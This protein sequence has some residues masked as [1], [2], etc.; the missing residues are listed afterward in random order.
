[1]AFGLV[2]YL[3]RAADSPKIESVRNAGLLF[4][5]NQAGVTGVDAGYSIPIGSQTLWMFGDVFLEDPLAPSKQVVGALSNCGLLVP[6]GTGAAALNRHEF[7]TDPATNLARQ[8]IP[9]LPGEDDKVRLWPF[10][11]WH[12][13]SAR[14]VY[15]F[16]GRVRVT[17][18]GPLDFHSDGQGLAAADTGNPK[19]LVFER[20]KDSRGELIWW[21]NAPDRPVFGSALLSRGEWVYVYGQRTA[22]GRRTAVLARVRSGHISDS[23]AYEYFAGQQ[24]GGAPVWSPD[25]RN[26]ADVPGLSDFPMELSVSYNAHLGGFLAVHSVNLTESVRL[27]TAAQ[28]WGPFRQIGDIGARRQPFSKAFCYAGKEH[29]ELSEDGGRIVYVTYVDNQRYWLRLLKITLSSSR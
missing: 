22:M 25:P 20:L 19:K 1:M 10:G 8:L 23:R 24:D 29:P 16:Y 17:G 3:N 2:T 21:P 4:T 6:R 18:N 15:L 28:P 27:S 13:Q 7:L 5:N 11:G 26:S 9:K 14:K 12:D